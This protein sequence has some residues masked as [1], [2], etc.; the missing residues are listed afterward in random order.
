MENG[1]NYLH[2]KTIVALPFP[3]F[4]PVWAHSYW[5]GQLEAWK[6]SAAVPGAQHFLSEHSQG[7]WQ[8]PHSLPRLGLLFSLSL[9]STG[10]R[11]QETRIWLPTSCRHPPQGRQKTIRP[12][13]SLSKKTNC[14]CIL[15]FCGH[16]GT[17]WQGSE[18]NSFWQSLR[19]MYDRETC[20][21]V[22]SRTA[23]LTPLWESGEP[24][25]RFSVFW[26]FD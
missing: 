23:V 2:V 13:P 18:L 19:T 3:R 14:I 25:S 26:S 22:H 9:L 21:P 16:T 15:P 12:V 4:Q 1:G 7:T 6:P 20:L 24:G 5:G 8:R 10:T 11:L 17:N